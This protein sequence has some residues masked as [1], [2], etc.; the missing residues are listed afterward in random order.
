VV[1][2]Y[3]LKKIE[4]FETEIKPNIILG[5]PI[6]ELDPHLQA[7][8][9]SFNY[10]LFLE[11]LISHKNIGL[12]SNVS[13]KINTTNKN[14]FRFANRFNANSSLFMI[15]KPFK[16]MKIM[17]E[18]GIS[19][20][21]SKRDVYNNEPFMDS[22]GRVTFLNYGIN[23]FIYKVGLTFTYYEPVKED[24]WDIQP[25]NKRRIISQLTYYF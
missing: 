3:K 11:Y 4:E 13:Y 5:S 23:L 10:I 22:G 17:P 24:L 9:G 6:M 7:G 1:I 8:T 2:N 16:K 21:Y 25:F 15:F 12:N 19:Y 20:E 18:I 14:G